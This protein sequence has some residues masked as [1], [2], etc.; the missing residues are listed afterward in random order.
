MFNQIRNAITLA[1]TMAV[2][3]ATFAAGTDVS[4]LGTELN[5]LGGTMAG[6]A[7]GSIPAWTG[8]LT[9]KVAGEHAGEKAVA[10]PPHPQPISNILCFSVR[11]S[12]AARRAIFRFCAISR[13]SVSLAK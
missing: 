6:N 4:K 2:V 7:D 13:S 9:E 3:P 11:F 1:V 5:P 12:F 10:S 8:G